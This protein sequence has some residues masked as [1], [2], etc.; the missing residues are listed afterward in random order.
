LVAILAADVAGYSRLMGADEVGTLTALKS[1][2]RELVDPAIAAHGGRIVKTTG[3]GMLV[4]FASAVDA[5]TCAM[6]VQSKMTERNAGVAH[7]IVFRIGIN[8]GDIIIDGDDIFGDGVNVAARVESECEPG[9]VYV[10]EDAFRQV[11]GRTPFEFENLG[12][13][14]LKNIE[15]AVRIYATRTATDA[16]PAAAAAKMEILPD[17][18]SQ[19]LTL[20]DKPSIAVLPF[21][22]MSGDPEQDYFADGTVEEIITALSRFKSLFVIAR[23]SSFTY[24]GR[25]VDIKQVGRELGVRYVLEGSVR[26]AGGRVRITGQLIECATG[27]HLWADKFDGDMAD[28]FELQ[29]SVTRSVVGAIAPRLLRAE[30]E[31]TQRKKPDSWTSYDHFM[32]GM[33]LFIQHTAVSNKEAISEFRKVLALDP[34]FGP[35]YARVAMC[36]F[37]LR[38]V[39]LVPV[40]EEERLEA[41]QMAAKA[42][43]LEPD[44]AHV[45]AITSIV[46]GSLNDEFERGAACAERAVAVNPNLA[47]AWNAR[48]WMSLHL[49]EPEVAVD[50]FGQSLRLNPLD[51]V[52]VPRILSGLATACLMSGKC[53]DGVRWSQQALVQQPHNLVALIMLA[54]NARRAGRKADAENAAARIRTL[55]PKLRVSDLRLMLRVRKPE[56]RDLIEELID[57][58]GLKG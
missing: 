20:P 11:R 32:R 10:S 45:L 3:D 51:P 38:N 30:I 28:V 57:D 40:T 8:I 49:G 14:S 35:A 6:T 24:K 16:K 55:A 50:A 25:A 33:A 9:G 7:K 1:H 41:L 15:Q 18:F 54:G 2:R 53:D 12:E 52:M 43:E 44:D 48:G 5:V 13:R 36:I 23:N 22:N 19:R 27:A 56:H 46:F 4:E 47:A 21:Q 42:G 17:D 31:F 37:H 58:L 26:K 34:G 29:D 39:F